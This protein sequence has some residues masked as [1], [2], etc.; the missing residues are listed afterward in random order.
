MSRAAKQVRPFL[1]PAC[2][3]AKNADRDTFIVQQHAATGRSAHR[4]A[5]KAQIILGGNSPEL[6]M[7]SRA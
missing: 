6:G 1:S 2:H 3:Q 5:M 4:S 7:P